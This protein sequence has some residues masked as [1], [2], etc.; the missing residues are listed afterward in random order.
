MS[1]YFCFTLNTQISTLNTSL[2]PKKKRM[3]KLSVNYH[4][5][6]NFYNFQVQINH[7]KVKW[8]L[9]ARIKPADTAIQIKPGMV[10]MIDGHQRGLRQPIWL[11]STTRIQQAQLIKLVSWQSKSDTHSRNLG[12]K[13]SASEFISIGPIE[14][15]IQNQPSISKIDTSGLFSNCNRIDCIQHQID[16]SLEK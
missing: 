16:D 13:S 9:L 7:Q 15:F 14:L 10:M 4:I 11:N 5:I 6:G 1:S 8:K 2:Q 3:L 12:S